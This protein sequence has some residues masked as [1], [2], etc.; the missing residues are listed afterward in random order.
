M[1]LPVFPNVQVYDV[2]GV[3][4]SDPDWVPASGSYIIYSFFNNASSRRTRETYAGLKSWAESE[5]VRLHTRSSE[6]FGSWRIPIPYIMAIVLPGEMHP[7]PEANISQDNCWDCGSSVL[8]PTTQCP[9]SAVLYCTGCNTFI[10][11]D[12]SFHTDRNSGVRYCNSCANVCVDCDSHYS[13]GFSEC[14]QCHHIERCN[15]C[16]GFWAEESMEWVDELEAYYCSSC[17]SGMCRNCNNMCSPDSLNEDRFCSACSF[18]SIGEEEESGETVETLE[19]P[20]IPGRENILRIGIEIEGGNGK[21]MSRTGHNL[22]RML[23]DVG[24][25]YYG[26][27]LGYHHY[28]E[29]PGYKVHVE[30][31]GSVDWEMVIGPLNMADASDVKILDDSV[32]VVRDM[33]RAKNARL[34]MR[35]GLHIHVEAAKAPLEKAYNLHRLYMFMEDWLYRVGAAK[36]P[37]HRAIFESRGHP[38][39]NPQLI[40]KLAFA[41]NLADNRYYGLSFS[42]YLATYF[43]ACN[44]GAR[45]YGLFEECT[46]QLGKCTFEFRLFNT[47]ANTTKVHAYLALSQALVAKALSMDEIGDDEYPELDFVKSKVEDFS[48]TKLRKYK[49]EWEKINQWVYDELPLTDQERQSIYY[50]IMNCEIGKVVDNTDIFLVGKENG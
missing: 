14:P 45:Q 29:A 27:M 40:G 22:A 10:D 7:D 11:S 35:A 30:R 9:C 4:I 50:C 6:P 39:K 31:D 13:P 23:R 33:I 43:G 37:H 2:N 42:N 34:D 8:F 19:I 18:N 46:C 49:K 47:T 5:D 36:W 12:G 44:C 17:S 21:G 28:R 24:L 48:P 41:R 25:S 1:S 16:G 3:I 38:Q 20:T 32:R 26:E 15:Y